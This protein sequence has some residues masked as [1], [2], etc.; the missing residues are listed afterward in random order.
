MYF[1]LRSGVREM[2]AY[3]L[4]RLN[5]SIDVNVNLIY[6]QTQAVRYL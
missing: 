2:C 1:Q 5:N 4:L 6:F 3:F